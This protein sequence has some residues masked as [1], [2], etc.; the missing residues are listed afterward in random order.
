MSTNNHGLGGMVSKE[1]AGLLSRAIRKGIELAKGL[2]TPPRFHFEEERLFSL[3]WDF[4]DEEDPD[5]RFCMTKAAF[6][7]RD[8]CEFILHCGSGFDDHV[9]FVTTEMK[10]FG[11]SPD[12]IEAYQTAAKSGAIRLLLWK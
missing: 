10:L 7:H 8:A 2:T 11:C 6:S 9:E 12:F 4:E 5:W 3:E 1:N